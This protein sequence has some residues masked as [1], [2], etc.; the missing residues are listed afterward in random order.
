MGCIEVTAL[1]MAFVLTWPAAA[2][3]ARPEGPNFKDIAEEAWALSEDKE[4]AGHFAKALGVE[5]E[6]TGRAPLV[7]KTKTATVKVKAKTGRCY[8]VPFAL[9]V[10]GMPS[11]AYKLQYSKS[12][13]AFALRSSPAIK[14]RSKTRT[15]WQAYGFCALDQGLVSMT[16]DADG[17]PGSK[18]KLRYAVLAYDRASTPERVREFLT[19]GPQTDICDAKQHAAFFRTPVPGT[20]AYLSSGEPVVML[21]RP[22]A[23]F[24]VLQLDGS[25]KRVSVKQLSGT[26]PTKLAFPE[27][28][29]WKGCP[30]NNTRGHAFAPASKAILA[31]EEKVRKKHAR[32]IAK[33]DS[34][35]R[36]LS[37]AGASK[38]GVDYGPAYNRDMKKRCDPLRKKAEKAFRTTFDELVD[39]FAEQRPADQVSQKRIEDAKSW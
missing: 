28:K 38:I 29:D 9:S 7:G 5:L 33:A 19:I 8:L 39:Q 22:E 30:N 31:C 26:P 10:G 23:Y 35:V 36:A 6:Q 16:V 20:L 4:A 24:E 11:G 37:N 27:L 3:A 14:A 1:S 17:A 13:Q 12:V 25:K 15:S 34:K 2:E 21:S 32:T 18:T